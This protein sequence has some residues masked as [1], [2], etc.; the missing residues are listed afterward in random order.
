MSYYGFTVTLTGDRKS[1][2]PD[3]CAH[4]MGSCAGVRSVLSRI[5]ALMEIKRDLK[6]F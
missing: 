2:K 4:Q 1:G 6:H 3:R 5:S